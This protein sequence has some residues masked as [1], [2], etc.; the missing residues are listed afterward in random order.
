M[1]VYKRNFKHGPRWCVYLTFK[2]GTRHRKVVGTKREAEKVEQKLRSEIVAGRWDLWEKQEVLFSDLVV[3]YL[4]YAE[5]SKSKSA[6]RCDKSRILNHLLPYFQHAP[7]DMIKPQMVDAYKAMRIRA[8]AAPKTIIL[9]LSN[10]SHML[11]MATRWRYIDKNVV[12]NVEKPKLIRNPPRFLSQE[13]I[14]RLIKEAHGSHIFPLIVTALHTGMRKSELLNLQWTDI[15]FAQGTTTVQSKEDWHTK[16]Y[17]S[18]TLQL[19]PFLRGILIQ[20]Q[21]RL[22]SEEISCLYVFTWKG[23]RI[24]Q[25]IRRSFGRVLRNAELDNCGVT[26]HTLR[27]TFASQLVMAGVN[28]RE[29]QQLMGHQ[30]YST[31][32]RYAHLSEDHVKRQVLKLPFANG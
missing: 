29:V 13:E 25:D 22:H 30:D 16:S 11:K 10:L 20:E 12:D 21:Q 26:L 18:R 7:L 23:E 14:Q 9:E 4:D 31:T 19:T 28:L 17:K 8:K 27:H 32:L 1:S 24:K 6:F 2:D 5:T 3:E 15:D